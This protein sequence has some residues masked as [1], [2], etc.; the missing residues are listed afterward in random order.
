[1]IVASESPAV[2]DA[3]SHLCDLLED[4]GA[5]FPPGLRIVH[6]D[7]QL[8]VWAD[9]EDPWLMRIPESTLVPVD[10]IV[11]AP[12]PPL[13]VIDAPG[14]TPLQRAVLDA[15]V[16]VMREAS[17][18]EHY[19]GTH[20]RATISDPQAVSILQS[21]HPAFSPAKDAGSML[22]TRTIRMTVHDE[23]SQSY[24]MP[25]LDLV[26][27]HPGSPAYLREDG[28]LSIA[29][30]QASP[31]GECFVS[32]GSTRDVLGIALAYGYLEDS[33]TRVNALPGDHPLPGG[34]TLR[35][36]RASRPEQSREADVITVIGAAFDATD[37]RV[38]R[39]SITQPVE[40]FLVDRGTAA[41]QARHT[42]RVVIRRIAA[43][44]LARL[45]R[46]HDSLRHFA[47]TELARSAIWRQQELLGAIG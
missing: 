29:T 20:P 25:M 23:D 13:Q 14:L 37:P 26:N 10:R 6:V 31:G 32:Y 5:L 46:A 34:G 47:G 18:W 44:D 3:L 15:C 40:R 4:A 11:W 41:I 8:S 39:E 42:A 28:Y 24:L 21:L 22:K 27:H 35:L 45:K 16:D 7:R 30:S 33:I 9:G 12:E 19:R 36:V 43:S 17:T 1:M 38:A 2:V